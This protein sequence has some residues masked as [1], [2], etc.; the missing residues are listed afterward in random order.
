[1]YGK[2]RFPLILLTL[3]LLASGCTRRFFREYADRDVEKLL[4]EKNVFEPWRIEQWHVYPD[5]RARF[6]DPSNPDRPPMPP[7]DPAAQYLSPNP[8]R[9]GKAGVGSFE[10]TGYFDLLAAWDA[11]NRASQT[12]KLVPVSGEAS[13]APNLPPPDAPPGTPEHP[14]LI[15]LEQCCELGLINS[16]DFQDQR[17]NLYLTALPVTLQRFSFAAQLFALGNAN[18]Q[19]SGSATATPGQR[20]TGSASDGVRKLMPTGASIL[21]QLANRFVF[22]LTNGSPTVSISNLTLNIAQPLLQGGGR[23]V[24]LEPLTQAERNLLYQ[25]RTYARFRKQFFVQI[26][27]GGG[28]G[29][30]GAALLDPALGALATAFGPTTGYLPTVRLVAN[31]E[32]DRE[33]VRRLTQYVRLFEAL[34]E[35]GE[36]SQLQV[37]T[38]RQSLLQGQATVLQDELQLRNSLDSFKIQLGMPPRTHIELDLAPIEPLREQFRRIQQPID[39]YQQLAEELRDANP[40]PNVPKK[41]RQPEEAGKLREKF[42]KLSRENE[43]VQ[44]TSFRERFQELWGLWEKLTEEQLEARLRD[45]QRQRRQLLDQRAKVEGDEAKTA[46]VNRRL[47]LVESETRIGTFEKALREYEKQ[48]WRQL[49]DAQ[50]AAARQNALYNVVADSFE[51]LFIEARNERLQIVRQ[52]W[53]DLPPICVEGVDLINAPLEE[54]YAKASQQALLNRLDLMNARAELVDR[55]RQIAV[56]AN[57]LFGV[58]DIGYSLDSATPTLPAQPLN[59]SSSRTTQ[60]LTING[61]LPLVRRFERNSYRTALINYQRERRALQLTEDSIVNSI[62]Q[63]LRQLRVLAETYKIQQQQVALAYNNVEQALEAFRQPATPSGAPGPPGAGSGQAGTAAALTQQI[64]SAQASLNRAQI[65]MYQIWIN[66]LSVRMRLYLNM[67]LMPLDARGVWIDDNANQCP[68]ERTSRSGTMPPIEPPT[69][70]AS[71]AL[72][73]VAPAPAIR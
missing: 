33:N 58:L 68:P 52:Q 66:Y 10:G 49:A 46:D 15:N 31:L 2:P 44:G 21:A 36:L 61:E 7:D 4:T 14:Y 56:R 35:G 24:T 30:A 1:M 9:P 12:P 27:A 54:A 13:P 5:P 16:R 71:A 50:A 70:G 45:M 64:Q 51:L 59:F 40:D 29:G 25:I 23:A 69:T 67:E 11:M 47:G 22:D 60:R 73:S 32:I 17:E 6:A 37:D 48:P 57:A 38:L 53:P 20:W 34:A 42:R 26:A 63:D 8:Q 18:F 39:E 41:Y 72:P 65:Q 3:I 43:L 55:W 28:G 62:R 19:N